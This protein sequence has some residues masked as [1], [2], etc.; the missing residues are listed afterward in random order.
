MLANMGSAFQVGMLVSLGTGHFILMTRG[1]GKDPLF[2]VSLWLWWICN[3]PSRASCVG[4]QS[5]GLVA[6]TVNGF[7]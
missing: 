6:S 5:P 2:T 1:L 4:E 3:K 7:P